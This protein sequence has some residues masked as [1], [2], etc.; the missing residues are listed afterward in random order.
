MSAA[1]P[2]HVATSHETIPAPS[3]QPLRN[4]PDMRAV[5]PLEVMLA[6]L[7]HVADDA[8][9]FVQRFRSYVAE[10]GFT[11]MAHFERDGTLCLNV[12]GPVDAQVRHRHRWMH[13]LVERLD[14]VEGGRA[15]LLRQLIDER[16][17]WDERP[18][19][20]RATTIA[21]RSFL[22]SGGR[23]LIDPAGRL[24]EEGDVAAWLCGPIERSS[25]I[26]AGY[27]AYFEMRNRHN[28]ARHIRRAV[29]LVGRWSDNGW[30]VLEAGA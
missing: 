8:V 30:R 9:A 23:L 4:E 25:A 5:T 10:I 18:V 12:G 11:V 19:D 17:A 21:I 7:A 27:R 24:R 16:I 15:L 28:A 22:L 6:Q 14:A 26:G 1:L 20:P 29:R 3:E 13:F 2:A